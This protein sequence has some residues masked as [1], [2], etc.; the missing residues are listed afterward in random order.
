M[1]SAVGEG[2]AIIDYQ[3]YKIYTWSGQ[4]TGLAVLTSDLLVTG[5]VPAIKDV[6]EVS[7]GNMPCVSGDVLNTYK[8]LGDALVKLVMP[9][10]PIV[11][12]VREFTTDRASAD[13]EAA[14]DDMQMFSLA[15]VKNGHAIS[16]NS[17]VSFGK[18]QSADAFKGMILLAPI[19][20]GDTRM[21]ESV[22]QDTDEAIMALLPALLNES[23]VQTKG[24]NLKMTSDLTVSDIEEMA[25]TQ[26]PSGL[27]AAVV[28]NLGSLTS[29]G[30]GLSIDASISN[31]TPMGLDMEEMHMAVTSKSGRIYSD[32][33]TAESSIP[34]GATTRFQRNIVIPLD[35]VSER[36]LLITV[37]GSAGALGRSIPFSASVSLTTGGIEGLISV[38]E[39]DVEVDFGE[40][41]ADGLHM[42]LQTNLSNSNP[43]G[44]DV[45]D[46][47]IVAKGQSG[48]VVLTKTITGFPIGPDATGTLSGDLLI[49]LG[50]LNESSIVITIQ[51]QVG[52]AGINLPINARVTM[53]VP[54]IEDFFTVPAINLAIDFG[55]LTSDALQTTL[56]TTLTNPNPFGID[57]GDVQIVAKGASDNVV[58]FSST[59]AGCSIGSFATGT[60]SGDLLI[61]L[62]MLDESGIVMTVQTQAGFGGLSIPINAQ[63]TI[64]MPD[65]DSLIVVPEIDLGV[66]F[67]EL[68]TS[69]LNMLLQT[70]LTNSNSLD[71]D[72]GDVQMVAKGESGNVIF[73]STMTG[74]SI[75]PGATKT[76]SAS[77]LMP[78]EI[79]TESSI[80]MTV[81]TE[82]GFA[83]ITLPI[84]AKMAIQMP[85]IESLIVIPEIDLGVDFG[86]LTSDGL[87]MMLQTTLTNPNP[88]GIDVG[89][90]Q[91]VAKG[92]SGNVIFSSIMAG[93]SIGP[94]DTETISGDL[95]IP[96]EILNESS[97]V[98]TVQTQAGFAGVT[99]PINAKVTVTMPDIASVIPGLSV[100]ISAEAD[101]GLLY[102]TF[103][104]ETIIDNPSSVDL[105]VDDIQVTLIDENGEVVD[106]MTI[107]GGTIT[108]GSSLTFSGSMTLS[109]SDLLSLL[110]SK[111]SIAMATEVGIAGL[112]ATIPVEAVVTMTLNLP[113]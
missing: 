80:V 33:D 14:L 92:Q 63:V 79:L 86:D 108:A 113:I 96:L 39:I 94:D 22:V 36:D 8:R 64:D 11:P 107:E 46:L 49:P 77:I 38:P 109:T 35:M 43:F 27:A 81:E 29:S 30:L 28:V 25:A 12:R 32:S 54:D 100:E 26:T 90:L 110:G 57:V 1:K 98:M 50:A 9:S 87:Q 31:N 18:R 83:G 42:G 2:F 16:L 15:M 84:D 75:G 93:C 20:I 102:S 91:I 4:E 58:F 65:I 13:V 111:F 60:I 17:V 89:D 67:G 41:T 103:A 88:F 21:P 104:V 85:D 40:L 5:S 34:A 71:L 106:T 37:D 55:E 73:A 97:V 66:S 61:P 52:L 7:E 82:V 105:I 19:L 76:I 24:S 99:L 10:E 3:G 69:G 45:G 70:T 74:C 78:L 59:M 95:L 6:I 56:Q 53:K 112:N 47:Q 44:L 101:F 62:D 72:V 68:T 51:T 48:N 23:D